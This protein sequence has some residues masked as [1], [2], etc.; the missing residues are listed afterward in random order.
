MKETLDSHPDYINLTQAMHK[1]TTVNN[2]MN[3]KMKIFDERQKVR[4][5][6]ARSTTAI[7]LVKPARYFIKEGKL[8]KICR[9]MD[10]AYIFILFSDLLIYAEKVG[11]KN[12]L[13]SNMLKFHKQIPID[14]SFNI[15][16]IP[17]N[18]KY[19]SKCWEIHSPVKSFIV[20][21]DH[22]GLKLEWMN[23]L[24]KVIIDRQ[25]IESTKQKTAALWVPDDFTDTCMMDDCVS[26]FTFV[27]RRHHCRYCGRLVC[28]T[29]SN[30][31]LPHWTNARKRVRS[32]TLCQL[33][34]NVCYCVRMVH[35]QT[36]CIVLNM[37][38]RRRKPVVCKV[39]K[40]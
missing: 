25:T 14:K 9:K 33:S 1:F 28:G 3:Q 12:D 16:D 11:T 20:Y 30:N 5:I 6:E 8:N 40:M 29:C 7:D 13:S 10:R 15:R 17:Q 18:M 35:T 2:T 32:C 38:Q 36:L 26:K 37:G 24:K 21:A 31:K 4:D 23:V 19:G 22:P 34:R 39:Y 27:N